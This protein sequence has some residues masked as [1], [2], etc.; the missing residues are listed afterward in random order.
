MKVQYKLILEIFVTVLLY[1]LGIIII[2]WLLWSRFIRERLPKDIPFELTEFRFYILVYICCVYLF[3]IYN[4]M[5]K[6]KE[7]NFIPYIKK[8]IEYILLNVHYVKVM[9]DQISGPIW[10]LPE[11][12]VLHPIMSSIELSRFLL[13]K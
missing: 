2:S 4:L 11:N 8:I 6:S 9:M 3:I 13:V 5:R 12:A 1:I 7:N 10:K